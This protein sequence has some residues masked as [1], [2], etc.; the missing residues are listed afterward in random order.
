MKGKLSYILLALM[1]AAG[2]I[3]WGIGM[4]ISSHTLSPRW[5]SLTAA[6][7]LALTSLPITLRSTRKRTT[8]QKI[9]RGILHLFMVGGVGFMAIMGINRLG[10]TEDKAET[11]IGEVTERV[12]H[13][14]NRHRRVGRN[15]Y[16]TDGYYYTYGATVTL[17]DGRQTEQHLSLEEYN[18][19]RTGA[20]REVAVARGWLGMPVVISVK[21]LSKN[22]A[23]E[24]LIRK[25]TTKEHEE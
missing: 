20:K 23:T 17:P 24:S 1:I 21:K 22:K 5:T 14:H 4:A 9:L 11:V 6:A 8:T 2:I 25:K 12:R 10:A 7:V 3:S 13:R 16:V 19:T 18:R 15:R